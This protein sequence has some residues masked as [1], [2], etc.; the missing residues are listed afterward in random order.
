MKFIVDQ[1][2]LISAGRDKTLQF[3]S[4]QTGRKLGTFE[5]QAW[6][7]DVE[8]PYETDSVFQNHLTVCLL[9]DY[10][11]VI[12]TGCFAGSHVFMLSLTLW[13]GEDMTRCPNTRLCRTIVVK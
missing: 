13:I 3:F 9:I 8:Y 10:E 2:W 5:A 6:C 7:L 12:Q 11:V 1:E 4:T